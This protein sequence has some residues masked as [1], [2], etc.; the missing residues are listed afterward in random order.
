[1]T[2]QAA[3]VLAVYRHIAKTVAALE[4]GRVQEVID[5]LAPDEQRKQRALTLAKKLIT[6]GDF[7]S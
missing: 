3:T 2:T 5:S 1:V 4:P 7:G 6:E